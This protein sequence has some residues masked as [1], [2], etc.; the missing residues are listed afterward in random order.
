MRW[1]VT[2]SPLRSRT[3]TLPALNHTAFNV[4]L[5][6]AAGGGVVEYDSNVNIFGLGIRSAPE[7]TALA[8]T[9]VR[10]AYK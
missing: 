9:S 10:A 3:F 5:P 1:A 7:G 8:F 6:A 4:L 2:L